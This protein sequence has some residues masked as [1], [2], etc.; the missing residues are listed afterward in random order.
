MVICYV[1]WT[2][3][4][5]ND[6]TKN[7]FYKHLWLVCLKWRVWDTVPYVNTSNSACVRLKSVPML[8]FISTRHDPIF[9]C[10]WLQQ[11]TY[12]R[13]FHRCDLF[14]TNEM[15]DSYLW[16]HGQKLLLFQMSLNVLS[17]DGFL[18]SISI[19]GG[20]IASIDRYF[21]SVRQI[22][23]VVNWYWGWWEAWSEYW[24]INGCAIRAPLIDPEILQSI[25]RIS[26]WLAVQ[27]IECTE[28][29]SGEF[30]TASNLYLFP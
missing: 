9:S 11:L 25:F 29:D 1:S 18:M 3:H 26:G 14:S 10:I 24:G 7:N 16:C 5:C 12:L 22:I 15:L 6:Q 8:F 13:C 28:Q 19:L 2:C 20:N 17:E 21:V 30:T 27:R 23:I 4:Y